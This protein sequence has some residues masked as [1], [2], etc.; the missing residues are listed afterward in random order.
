MDELM[1]R[2]LNC[3]GISAIIALSV[4]CLT[5]GGCLV[6]DFFC[7]LSFCGI[8][9]D[10]LLSLFFGLLFC[11]IGLSLIALILII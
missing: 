3:L 11:I 9:V 5:G 8:T 1:C 4:I 10:G 7:D 2:I 6:K